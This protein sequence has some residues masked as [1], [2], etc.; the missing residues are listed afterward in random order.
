[1]MTTDNI[2]FYANVYF[3]VDVNIDDISSFLAN[4]KKLIYTN[5]I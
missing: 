1:M 3:F 5:L 4:N 2:E